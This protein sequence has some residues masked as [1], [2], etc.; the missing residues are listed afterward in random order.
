MNNAR[1][2]GNNIRLELKKKSMELSEFADKT[3]FSV[4][5]VHK[6]IEGR[7][8]LPPAQLNEIADVLH[9]TRE[10][11]LAYRGQEEYNLSVE[12]FR[13][14]RNEENQELVLDLIDMYA[15]LAETL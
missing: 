5:D 7:L 12:N 8:F 15:D 10:R 13:E 1:V 2:I 11:L 3:G 6:L 14:F 9:I 4:A